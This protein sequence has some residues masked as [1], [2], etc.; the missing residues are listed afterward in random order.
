MQICVMLDMVRAFKVVKN[1]VNLNPD[2]SKE[3]TIFQ[4]QYNIFRT[5][6]L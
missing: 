2:K 4:S 5:C 1:I 3:E 6:Q